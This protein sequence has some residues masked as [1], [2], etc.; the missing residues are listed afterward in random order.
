MDRLENSFFE[1]QGLKPLVW[2]R[3]ID[4]IFFIWTHSEKE[5]KEFMTELNYFDSSS[6]IKFT[7]EYSDKKVSFLDLQV[8]IVEGKL[9]TSLFVK[10]TDRHQYLHYSSGHPEHTKRSII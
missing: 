3:Y 1:T 10:L 9:I 4:D 2:L 8:D 5:L 7:Y 6:N